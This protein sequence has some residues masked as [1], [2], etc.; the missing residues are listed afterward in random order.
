MRR[1][2][3]KVPLRAVKDVK[4]GCHTGAIPEPW[5][6]RELSFSRLHAV[7]LHAPQGHHD[8][9]GHDFTAYINGDTRPDEAKFR[10]PIPRLMEHPR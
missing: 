10:R 4:G 1:Q 3:E 7:S 9:K 8:S 5:S 6:Q 2:G